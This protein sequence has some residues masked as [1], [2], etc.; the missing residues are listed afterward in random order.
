M[1]RRYS[2]WNI[3]TNKGGEHL[4]YDKKTDIRTVYEYT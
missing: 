1:E 4:A 2:S 3:N